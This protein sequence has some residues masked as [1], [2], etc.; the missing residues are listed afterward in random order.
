MAHGASINLT[1]RQF[2]CPH[3]YVVRLTSPSLALGVKKHAPMHALGMF[4]ATDGKKSRFVD[5][6]RMYRLI[7]ETIARCAPIGL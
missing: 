5:T 1:V 4:A 7:K 3:D 6:Y 2:K